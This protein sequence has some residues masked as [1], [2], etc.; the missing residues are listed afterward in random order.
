V[1]SGSENPGRPR[2]RSAADAGFTL[3][4]LA[5]TLAIVGILAAYAIPRIVDNT[6]FTSRGAFDRA[7][8]LVA[9]A[10][11][12]AVAQR[13]SPPKNPIYVDISAA[14]IRVC[15]DAACT[16]PVSDPASGAA[17]VLDAPAGVTFGPVTIFSFDGS[18]AP[19]FGA[20]LG[21]TV[22]STGAG[23]VNRTFFVEARSGYVHD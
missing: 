10:R 23:D 16:A 17:L 5:A 7:Q 4:E 1:F 11:R 22:T 20:P 2:L 14:R 21:V 19:S 15:Y 12:I 13:Q 8:G 3:V 18:G 9:S 6:G